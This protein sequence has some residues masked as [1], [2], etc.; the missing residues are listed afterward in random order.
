MFGSL[1][2]ACIGDFWYDDTNIFEN[3]F[4]IS[5][6]GG[7]DEDISKRYVSISSED[8]QYARYA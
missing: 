6:G 5:S 1:G 8:S 4:G 7:N 2:M 3:A